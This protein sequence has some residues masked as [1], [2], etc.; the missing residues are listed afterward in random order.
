MEPS[1]AQYLIINALQSLE[2]MTYNIYEPDR[3]L[4]FIATL[5]LILPIAAISQDGEIYP[6]EWVQDNDNN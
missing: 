5:S 6:L 3:G 2:L 1:D 4:W